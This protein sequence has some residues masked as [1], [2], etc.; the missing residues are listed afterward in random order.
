MRMKF[1]L[2]LSLSTLSCFCNAQVAPSTR[3]N[4]GGT[5]LTVGGGFSAF[6]PNY[7]TN[8]MYGFTAY[9]DFTFF[10]GLG[11][12]AEGRSI[13]LN[14]W[15]NKVREDNF[16]GGARYEVIHHGQFRPYVKALAGLGSIDFPGTI[17]TH[18]TFG[19]YSFG[20]GVDYRFTR[21]IYFRGDYEYSYWRH[22][23]G[24]HDLNPNGVT[25]G[26][27]YRIF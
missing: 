21:R 2:V 12:E 9:S 23:F 25:L 22:T 19:M 11:V 16:A 13:F 1:L 17:Y 4:L 6:R 26:V 18:D 15:D 7:G 20:G 27:S 14:K 3:G 24:P 10:H 8:E 5:V